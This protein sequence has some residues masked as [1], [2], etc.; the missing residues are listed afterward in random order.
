MPTFE[1][2]L[3]RVASLAGLGE[4]V[5]ALVKESG[6]AKPKR[7]VKRSVAKAAA[8]KVVRPRPTI[9]DND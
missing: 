7:R 5:L 4:R 3:E 2:G 8:R 6:L 1:E 9:A